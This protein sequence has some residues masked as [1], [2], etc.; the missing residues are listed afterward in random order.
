MDNKGVFLVVFS[1][2]GEEKLGGEGGIGD[3]KAIRSR[4]QD[5]CTPGGFIVFIGFALVWGSTEGM[6]RPK[7][8]TLNPKS[9]GPKPQTLNPKP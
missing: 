4:Y 2:V 6:T 5:R 9:Q 3:E 1:F 8:L 7:P